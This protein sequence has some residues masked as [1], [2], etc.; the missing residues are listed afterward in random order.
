MEIFQL[1]GKC[2]EHL[3]FLTDIKP[4]VFEIILYQ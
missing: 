4:I 3:Y 2:I 1:I